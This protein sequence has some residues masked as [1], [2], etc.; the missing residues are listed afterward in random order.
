[1]T[2]LLEGGSLDASDVVEVEGRRAFRDGA[3]A[4]DPAGTRPRLYF[5]L[6]PEVKAAKNRLHLDVRTLTKDLEAEV[7]RV[8]SL[9][10]SLVE[11]NHQGAHRWAVMRDPEGNEFCLT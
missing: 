7:E 9:G 11:F 3:G 1:M 6:V 10:A 4:F 5:Q 8:A 2:E